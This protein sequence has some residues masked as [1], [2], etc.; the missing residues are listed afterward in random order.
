MRP[1]ASEVV[2]FSHQEINK[3]NKHY[4]T[5]YIKHTLKR[6]KC[7]SYT[8]HVHVYMY[9]FFVNVAHEKRFKMLRGHSGKVSP[10]F[11]VCSSPVCASLIGLWRKC[12]LAYVERK[13]GRAV[14][15]YQLGQRRRGGHK[16]ERS[17][18]GET[19]RLTAGEMRLKEPRKRAKSPKNAS[20]GT[21]DDGG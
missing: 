2:L 10:S 4:L 11:G 16:R 6:F 13:V 19:E 15:G 7:N 8:R 17:E 12:S 9:I 3:N 18:A 5:G 1:L 21:T 14:G 20:L